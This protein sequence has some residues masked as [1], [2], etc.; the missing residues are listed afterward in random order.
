MPMRESTRQCTQEHEHEHE[1]EHEP[2]DLVELLLHLSDALGEAL[3]V[4][5][6]QLVVLHRPAKL[7]LRASPAPP[8]MHVPCQPRCHAMA[9]ST[10]CAQ[11]RAVAQW[12]GGSVAYLLLLG[13]DLEVLV[14]GLLLHARDT[15]T[16]KESQ[17]PR[18]LAML[19]HE[20][21]DVQQVRPS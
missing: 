20:G 11:A 18:W 19:A 9:A 15:R 4:E 6:Q 5:A 17:Q 10:W 14:L 12:L 21:I 3:V 16:H 7:H 13:L 1:H 2:P 8:I